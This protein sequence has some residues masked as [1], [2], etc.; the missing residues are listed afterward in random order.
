M[1][2]LDAA[3]IIAKPLAALHVRFLQRLLEVSAE[4]LR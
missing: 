3:A 4:C 1:Q 2:K